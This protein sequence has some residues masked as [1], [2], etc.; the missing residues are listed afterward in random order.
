[1]LDIEA[2]LAVLG[3]SPLSET[4][5]ISKTLKEAFSITLLPPTTWQDGSSACTLI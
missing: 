2:Q 1:M 5:G 3:P 4:K